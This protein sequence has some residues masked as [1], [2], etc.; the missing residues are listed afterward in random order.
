MVFV[1]TER[2]NFSD[3]HVWYS[4]KTRQEAS[5][6]LQTWKKKKTEI[7]NAAGSLP[8]SVCVQYFVPLHPDCC[9]D[10][11]MHCST[12]IVSL[13]TLPSNITASCYC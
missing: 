7:M 2:N 11:K 9:I 8:L 13:L 12:I 1:L 6:A 5:R 3:Y 10:D 4:E